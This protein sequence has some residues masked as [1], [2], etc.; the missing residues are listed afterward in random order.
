M[1][2]IEFDWDVTNPYNDKKPE[3]RHFGIEA[4]YSP[5]LAVQD[6]GANY[7]SIDMGKQV[8]LNSLANKKLIAELKETKQ[9]L[10]DL[11][12]LLTEKGVI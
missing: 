2:F 8:N 4:Q 9:E 6:K 3:G 1:R 10:A 12:A 11:K 5:F 7:L